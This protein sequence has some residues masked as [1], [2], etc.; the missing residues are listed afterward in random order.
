M[1]FFPNLG[2]SLNCVITPLYNTTI[3]DYKTTIL[4][5]L[6]CRLLDIFLLD[7]EYISYEKP[8]RNVFQTSMHVSFAG[9][10]LPLCTGSC[11]THSNPSWHF[12]WY[13]IKNFI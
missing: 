10:F 3:T 7:K 8:L 11:H 12:S 1:D 6:F 13:T 4:Q 5:L 2:N 9:S